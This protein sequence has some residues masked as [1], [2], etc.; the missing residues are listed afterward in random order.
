MTPIEI[1]NEALDAAKSAVKE[2]ESKY[3][4]K[5]PQH[6][7]CGYAYVHIDSKLD[8]FVKGMKKALKERGVKY[9]SAG[10]LRNLDGGF[11]N[12]SYN[13]VSGFGSMRDF[14]SPGYPK[15]WQFANPGKTRWQDMDAKLVGCR[16]F[17]EVLREN[18]IPAYTS[19]RLD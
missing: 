8:P 14:G 12:G 15:G 6:L 5:E 16:A 2:Y 1:L 10:N 7:N 18:G 9:D 19:C 17:A 11:Y 13:D 3:D 4:F